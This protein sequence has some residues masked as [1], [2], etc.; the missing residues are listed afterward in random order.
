MISISLS[1]VEWRSEVLELEMTT[2]LGDPVRVYGLSAQDYT[3]RMPQS[4]FAREVMPF[5]L[6]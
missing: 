1:L 6:R 2:V 5:R 4:G 3:G